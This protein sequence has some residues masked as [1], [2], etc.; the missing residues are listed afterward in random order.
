MSQGNGSEL[1]QGEFRTGTGKKLFTE[2]VVKQWNKLPREVV[3]APS[4]SML[5]KRL[6]NALKYV[7]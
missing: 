5:K 4:L 2:R 6:D 7:V 3:M 1:H